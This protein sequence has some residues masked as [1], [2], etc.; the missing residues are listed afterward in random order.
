MD[1]KNRS[2]QVRK[3]GGTQFVGLAG[4]VKRVGKQ[5]QSIDESR[6]FG[7]QDAGLT[8]AIGLPSEPNLPGILL[9]SCH[10]LLAQALPVACGIPRMGW[11]FGAILP[12][13]QIVAQHFCFVRGRFVR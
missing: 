7:G 2:V 1:E 9:A 3:V 6:R 8:A 4:R 12:E 11:P 5:E 13:G 10:E